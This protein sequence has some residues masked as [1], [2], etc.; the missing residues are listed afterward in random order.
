MLFADLVGFTTLSEPRD[1]EEVRELLSRYFDTAAPSIGRYGGTVEKFIGDAVMA[2]WG[3]PVAQEDD[4]ER[5]VRAALDLVDGGGGARRRG[6][7]AG[8]ARRAPVCSRARRRSTSAPRARAW[9]RA[10]SSTPPPASS[11]IAEPGTVLVGDATRR[12]SEAAIAYEDAGE[13]ELKG[14]AEP[15]ALWRAVRVLAGAAGA[16]A[17]DGLEAPF[18]GR[19]RELRLVKELFHAT[20][21]ERRAHLVSVIGIGGIGKSRLGWEFYKYID[22]LADD[23]WWH[24]GRCLAYG[25]GV[26]Y[27][28]LAE[29]VRMRAR[30]RSR[31]RTPRRRRAK[32]AARRSSSTSPDD[33]ER[34]LGGAAA[35][36]PARAEE[37]AGPATGEDLFSAWRLFF[38]RL[39]E[40]GP[41]VLVFEDLHWADAAL[42]DF[43]EYLLEW[44]RS[45]ASS[46]SRWRGPSCRAAARPGARRAQLDQRS[47]LEPLPDAGDGRLLQG[48]FPAFRTTLRSRSRPRRGR[49]ALR[50]RDGADAPRPRAAGPRT[51]RLPADRRV[52]HPRGPGDAARAHRRPAGRA[53]RRPSAVSSQDAAVLGKTF[54]KRAL[55]ALAG[56]AEAELEPLLALVRKEML[57]LQARPAV[58]GARP[59]R[60]SCRSSA[61]V[62]YETL[63]RRER[64][65][66]HLAAVAA[67][68]RASPGSSRKCPR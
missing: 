24:R 7:R 11:R 65:A 33:A 17:L 40:R 60:L 37:R 20:A 30:D 44:S 27:W 46:S 63:S 56:P 64:K 12:A 25:E 61:R 48:L 32:L 26:A 52:E 23:V 31:T 4:A 49:A 55:A 58:A 39:A 10:I 51:A 57:A 42:L 6:R 54:T 68:V 35:R 18:V 43:V 62:A 15:V 14:K 66:R 5:A 45:T 36:A 9:L 2:V 41:I 19:D 3:A 38:E 16:P 21:D 1:A 67:L 28:A 53:R 8:A 47:R 50:R 34:G 29:M 22:G 13:H 59:V